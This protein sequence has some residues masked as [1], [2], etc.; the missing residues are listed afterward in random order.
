MNSAS[1]SPSVSLND[2]IVYKRLGIIASG[3]RA[4]VVDKEVASNVIFSCE[5]SSVVLQLEEGISSATK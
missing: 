5:R 3:K 1:N 2:E 4:S